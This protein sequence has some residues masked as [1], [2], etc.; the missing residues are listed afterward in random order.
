[1]TRVLFVGS[2]A[3]GEPTLKALAGRGQCVCVV[4]GTDKKA[5]RKQKLTPTPIGACAEAL[6]L[7]CI[8]TDNIN[9][10][11]RIHEIEFDT[12][13]VIAFGQKLSDELIEKYDAV[14]LHASLLPRWRGAAP[15]H[16]AIMHGDSETGVSVITLAST[17]DG[18]LVLAS[19]STAIG[20]EETTGDLHDRL[21][22]MGPEV[23]ERVLQGE[24]LNAIQDESQVTYA[25][26]LSRKDAVLDLSLNSEV[27]ARQIRGLSPWP[28]CHLIIGGVDCKLLNAKAVSGTGTAGEIIDGH[29]IACGEGA[30]EIAELKPSGGKAMGWQEFCNGRSIK[31]GDFCEVPT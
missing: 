18:G 9:A 17:M 29:A 15:I 11:H 24:R 1:M 28:S 27:I 10:E 14:N 16:A 25:S 3:F 30:I 26:K 4:T 20:V 5:G 13:V 6:G 21:A 2:G 8:K 12:M 7:P 19:T 23:I 22:Q 31:V